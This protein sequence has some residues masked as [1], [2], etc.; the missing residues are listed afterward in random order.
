MSDLQLVSYTDLYFCY[1][2][3]FADK[4]ILAPHVIMSYLL[5]PTC[6][7]CSPTIDRHCYALIG[8]D[9]KGKAESQLHTNKGHL[10]GHHSNLFLFATDGACVCVHV[11]VWSSV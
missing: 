10:K 2:N 8:K 4:A 5:C 7:R 3:S 6:T 1:G 11:I 9:I